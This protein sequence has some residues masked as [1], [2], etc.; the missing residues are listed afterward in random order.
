MEDVI[1]IDSNIWCYYFNESA[2]EHEIISIALEG[3]LSTQGVAITSVILME[4][5]HYLYR[6]IPGKAGSLIDTFLTYPFQFYEL[7][8]KTVHHAIQILEQYALYGIGGRDA[9]IIASMELSGIK[10]LMTNDKSFV[11]VKSIEVINPLQ[12]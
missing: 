8:L 5:A 3:I 2:P 9:T 1:F 12:K 4:V 6:Q 10:Y 7:D 11:N